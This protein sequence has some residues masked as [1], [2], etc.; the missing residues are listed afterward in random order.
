MQDVPK[1]IE[2]F[3]YI[4]VLNGFRLERYVQGKKE[5]E[6]AENHFIIVVLYF[7]V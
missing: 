7:T 5:M 6:E 3:R 2:N 1:T 4:F